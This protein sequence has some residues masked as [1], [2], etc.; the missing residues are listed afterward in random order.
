MRLSQKLK[1]TTLGKWF[2]QKISRMYP[3]EAYTA[4]LK[5]FTTVDAVQ[6]RAANLAVRDGLMR[7]DQRHG[8][9]GALA[10]IELP[11]AE[12]GELSGELLEE[13]LD[14]Y[15]PKAGLNPAVVTGLSDEQVD[16]YIKSGTQG[17]I[18]L[19]QLLW[20]R[21]HINTDQVGREVSRPSDVLKEGDVIWVAL[22]GCRTTGFGA[23]ARGRRGAGCVKSR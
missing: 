2:A 8:Y 17:V 19:E 12:D 1:L 18:G 6:Q 10:S 7:I 5:V 21:K 22:N 9:R 13:Q 23:V 11:V 14:A 16:V 4:G 15:S 3:G 20:A